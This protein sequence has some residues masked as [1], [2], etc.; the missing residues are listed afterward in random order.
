METDLHAVLLIVS[1]IAAAVVVWRFRKRTW[2]VTGIVQ[3][4]AIGVVAGVL[5]S[6][7]VTPM[8]P[9]PTPWAQL[10]LPVALGAVGWVLLVPPWRLVFFMTMVAI[11]VGLSVHFYSL[12]L[13][14]TA[15]P[16]TPLV[17]GVA[18]ECSGAGSRGTRWHSFFTGL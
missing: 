14:P 2:S 8:C 4:S 10:W 5:V 16:G 1:A 3:G 18:S 6:A 9:V 12:Q 11:G 7:F 17:A 13:G 15:S